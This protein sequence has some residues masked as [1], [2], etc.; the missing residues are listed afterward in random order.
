MIC[1]L[2]DFFLSF[3]RAP[4]DQH[5]HHLQKSAVIKLRKHA[6][7][8]RTKSIA[9]NKG[10]LLQNS[11]IIHLNCLIAGIGLKLR[12]ANIKLIT[13]EKQIQTQATMM[14]VQSRSQRTRNL[15]APTRNKDSMLRKSNETPMQPTRRRERKTRKKSEEKSS[16]RE[17]KAPSS[18]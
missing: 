3:F 14:T 7:S 10:K 12:K 2:N 13:S 9:A 6:I 15:P 18:T 8:Q 1:V 5:H 11:K 17:V 4:S 16:S